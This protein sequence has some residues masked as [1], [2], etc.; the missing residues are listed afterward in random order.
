MISLF[1]NMSRPSFAFIEEPLVDVAGMSPSE[2]AGL[3]W[4]T[5]CGPTF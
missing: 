1:C 3:A 5:G 2:P 4:M